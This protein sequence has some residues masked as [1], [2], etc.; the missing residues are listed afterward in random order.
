MDKMTLARIEVKNPYQKLQVE[1]KE[2]YGLSQIEA[3]ALISRV[4]Q[5]NEDL[6]DD[7]RSHN[8]ILRQVVVIGEPSGKK[9]RECRL[10]NVNSIPKKA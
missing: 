6:H 10:I 5:F 2:D 1:L 3:R 8:Q 9:L 7:R 4:E